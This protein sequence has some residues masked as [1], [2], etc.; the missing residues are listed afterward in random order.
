MDT[1]AYLNAIL[2][3]RVYPESRAIEYPVVGLANE[4]GEALGV[5]KKAIRGDYSLNVA[6]ENFSAHHKHLLIDEIGDVLWYAAI[7]LYDLDSTLEEAMEMNILKVNRRK[8]AG[9]LKGDGSDR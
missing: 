8:A 1:A 3:A 7:A 4:A 2:K 9:L 6:D 5:V